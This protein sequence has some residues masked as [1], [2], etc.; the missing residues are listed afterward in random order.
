[1]TDS[2]TILTCDQAFFSRRK[3]RVIR[4]GEGWGAGGAD[5][6]LGQS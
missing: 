2:R 6:R 1:M 4:E 3:K 5:R